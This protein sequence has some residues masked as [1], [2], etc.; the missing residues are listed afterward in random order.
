MKVYKVTAKCG[1]VGRN[2]YVIKSFPV[3]ASDGKEAARIARN[4][5]R[6]KHHHKDAIIS[7]EEI[8]LAEY[9][10]LIRQN[11]SDPYFSCQNVQDQRKYE[12]VIYSEHSQ[13]K[14]YSEISHKTVY[15]GKEILRNPK[16][17]MR[18]I[19]YAE[20]YAI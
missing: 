15:Y 5:P 12:E 16:K 3:Q 20:R 17:F 19:N 14:N 8:T 9:Y 18:N 13:K 2:Y 1:H 4:I 11:N 10:A 7:V 6:V